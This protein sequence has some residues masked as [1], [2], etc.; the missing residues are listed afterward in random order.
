MSKVGQMFFPL[1]LFSSVTRQSD[2]HNLKPFDS[3]VA[4]CTQAYVHVYV[5]DLTSSF[6]HMMRSDLKTFTQT[7]N[8]MLNSMLQTD[9]WEVAEASVLPPGAWRCEPSPVE[10]TALVRTGCNYQA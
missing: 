4:A 2:S 5:H 7:L 10:Q 9:V 3:S 8:V 1:N 6:S